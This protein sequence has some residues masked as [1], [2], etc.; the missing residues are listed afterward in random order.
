MEGSGYWVI[1]A[2]IYLLSMWAK[3]KQQIARR[4]KLEQEDDDAPVLTAQP[5]GQP[6]DFL[7]KLFKDAGF[8]LVEDEEDTEIAEEYSEPEYQPPPEQPSEITI[9]ERMAEF[10]RVVAAVEPVSEGPLDSERVVFRR[11]QENHID[12]ARTNR[13]L[14][15]DISNADALQRAI[16]LKEIL[17]KPRSLR[18]K[19][20]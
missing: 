20:R 13:C 11:Q 2:L 3:K 4:E 8:D 15:P 10:D 17:D 1:L 6:P 5:A 9:R 12:S 16:I 19:I 18:R 7:S 14:I